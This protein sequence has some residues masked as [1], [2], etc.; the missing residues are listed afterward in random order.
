VEDVIEP[1]VENAVKVVT[2][3]GR[4]FSDD[5]HPP[6]QTPLQRTNT[7]LYGPGGSAAAP[8]PAPVPPADQAGGLNDGATNAG[9]QYNKHV[10]GAALTDDKLATLL[11]QI[12]E[13]NQQARDKVNAIL[14]DIQAK[15]KQIAPEMGDPASVMAF[16]K[17]MDTKFG[18]IQKVL[19]DSQVDAKT[20]AAIMDA[21]GQEYRTNGPKSGEG[22]DKGSGG[23]E[24]G[25]GGDS[26]G[27]GGGGDA[28]PPPADAGAGAPA[29]AGAGTDPLTDP[30]A[31]MGPMG[32][33]GMGGDP[34]SSLAGLGS[35]LPGMLGGL[36]A[37]GS[38]LDSLGG[39]LGGLGSALPGL[40]SQFSDK[41]GQDPAST[42]D[43][44]SDTKGDGKADKPEDAF[45]DDQGKTDDPPADK[46]KED[47]KAP[48][49]PNTVQPVANTPAAAA[50]AA[51]P[52]VDGHTVS[53]PDGTSVNASDDQRKNAM[54]AVINGKSVSDAYGG[55]I[56]PAGS[57][58]MNPVDRNSLRPGDYAQ[59]EA[60]PAVMY[61]GNGK[62]WLDGQLKPV[63]ALPSSS[64]FLGWTGP[65]AAGGGTQASVPAPATG[66]PASA[67]VTTAPPTGN[68]TA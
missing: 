1:A 48:A 14:A 58:V 65:P 17:Y 25:S 51:A 3:V 45:K 30:L 4:V 29:D 40:A 63:S 53:L 61:M 2:A 15:S 43:T 37:G 9:D 36:G 24:G 21:L 39:A 27:G 52:S 19:S 13:S 16:Q 57:P 62:I 33:G 42:D 67:S 28:A 54:E 35:S 38:P 60:K 41:N 66:T 11:K 49:D 7:A 46:G 50:P 12:F 23:S 47:A 44:F 22:E 6:S 55:Q 26:S 18:E 56:P 32:M 68:H 8:P 34:L 20:Q 5:D 64:D 59:F 10:D 31:G